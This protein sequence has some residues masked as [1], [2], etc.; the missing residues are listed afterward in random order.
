MSRSTNP[1]PV[2]NK[3]SYLKSNIGRRTGGPGWIRAVDESGETLAMLVLNESDN[4]TIRPPIQIY[5]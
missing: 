3:W 5:M 1:P 4:I 2:D